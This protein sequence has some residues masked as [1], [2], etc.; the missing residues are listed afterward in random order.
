MKFVPLHS[1]QISPSIDAWLSC[2]S[3]K[4]A[5]TKFMFW[6]V[7]SLQ[8]S[9][10]ANLCLAVSSLSKIQRAPIYV[11]WCLPSAKS[12]STIYMSR[13]VCLWNLIWRVWMSKIIPRSRTCVW[14]AALLLSEISCASGHDCFGAVLKASFEDFMFAVFELMEIDKH[15]V[16]S[17]WLVVPDMTWCAVCESTK[18]VEEFRHGPVCC[19]WRLIET[20]GRKNHVFPCVL[21]LF[22]VFQIFG[23]VRNGIESSRLSFSKSE[24]IA[25]MFVYLARLL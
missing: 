14:F 11:S 15:G 19:L 13:G 6:V 4:S 17:K 20:I 8:K 18:S 7:F 2:P 12:T 10:C 5:K 23:S 21:T 25:H 24:R 3:P 16:L 9:R 1:F 22:I